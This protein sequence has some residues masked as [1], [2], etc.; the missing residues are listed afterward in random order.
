MST[1]FFTDYHDWQ[2]KQ[3]A[4]LLP[5]HC[6]TCDQDLTEEQG[7]EHR[8]HDHK[9]VMQ[10]ST[11]EK[12]ARITEWRALAKKARAASQAGA[13]AM[14]TQLADKLENDLTRN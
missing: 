8:R 4:E 10:L 2:R 9:I 13:E 7:W 5:C 11:K 12:L 6:V 1:A 14:F 3:T